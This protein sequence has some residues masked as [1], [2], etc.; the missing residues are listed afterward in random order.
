MIEIKNLTAKQVKFLDFFW[1]CET[2][3]G[4]EAFIFFLDE[5]DK[6][7]ARSLVE[8]LQVESMDSLVGEC[9]DAKEVLWRIMYC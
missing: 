6:K 3:E 7:I 5:E 9:E 1:K 2:R 4:V 8:L